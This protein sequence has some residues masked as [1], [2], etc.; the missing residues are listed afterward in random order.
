MRQNYAYDLY[1]RELVG[2]EEKWNLTQNGADFQGMKYRLKYIVSDFIL[3]SMLR[4]V[5]YT[6]ECEEGG[7]EIPSSHMTY[8]VTFDDTPPGDGGLE[9]T[10]N[11]QTEVNPGVEDSLVYKTVI[12]P[13]T[14]A[15]LA[16]VRF[17]ML[18]VLRTNTPNPIGVNFLETVVGFTANLTS[19]FGVSA[20]VG[21]KEKI[22]T[23][24]AES[25]NVNAYLCDEYNEE[26]TGSA[27]TNARTQG[28]IVRACVTPDQDA[29]DDGVFMKAIQDFTWFRDYGGGLGMVSQVAVQDSQAASNLLTILYCTPGSITCAFESILFASMFLTPGDVSGTGTALLQLGDSSEE[30]KRRGLE[31][32]SLSRSLQDAGDLPAT[33][34]G[35]EFDLRLGEEYTGTLKTASSPKLELMHSIATMGTIALIN[36][37]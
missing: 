7:V 19:G 31:S 12:D 25:Y 4:T 21:P 34:F 22:V 8:E 20:N 6:E 23:T 1:P 17:C 37:L 28:Q 10:F 30:R 32:S 27:L 14:G 3:E 24:A 29:R 26:L 33:D 16:E 2:L 5:A 9:R 13:E 15:K 36:L 18:T 11:I 35:L